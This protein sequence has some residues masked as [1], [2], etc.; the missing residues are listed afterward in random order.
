MI[1]MEIYLKWINK[2][3]LISLEYPD[4]LLASPAVDPMRKPLMKRTT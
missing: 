4:N 3:R 2:I 1:T